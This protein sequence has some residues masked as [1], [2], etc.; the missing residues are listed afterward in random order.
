[1]CQAAP[2]WPSPHLPASQLPRPAPGRRPCPALPES[3]A[4]K[5]GGKAGRLPPPRGAAP[6]GGPGSLGCRLG[7]SSAAQWHVGP[8]DLAGS[9]ATPPH[10]L[11]AGGL[12]SQERA[13]VLNGT[14]GS[15]GRRGAVGPSGVAGAGAWGAPDEAQARN[16]GRA[17]DVASAAD[18]ALAE[19]RCRRP[20]GP[21]EATRGAAHPA[22]RLAR[23]RGAWGRRP[24]KRQVRENIS[25]RQSGATRRRTPRPAQRA[26]CASARPTSRQRSR[27]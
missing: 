14:P 16:E 1:M 4:P 25:A 12:R 11:G 6:R 2:G 24:Q 10:H 9:L 8:S 15:P 5:A 27:R 17:R 13:E 21:R 19:S 18:A 22:A 7:P 26:A 20:P 3:S 23:P